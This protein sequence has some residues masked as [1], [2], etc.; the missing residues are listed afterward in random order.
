MKWALRNRI[1]TW[2][3]LLMIVRTMKPQRI[4]CG[5]R[6]RIKEV[7]DDEVSTA[8]SYRLMG[9]VA[10]HREDR[11]AAERWYRKSLELGEKVDDAVGIAQT[12]FCLSQNARDRNNNKAAEEWLQ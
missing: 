5:N 3:P 7:Y 9:T 10:S 6:S 12:Y 8:N 11:D 1:T 2:A 4:G